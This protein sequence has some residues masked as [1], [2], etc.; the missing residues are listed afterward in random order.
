MSCRLH[1]DL[2]SWIKLGSLP[3]LEK[4]SFDWLVKSKLLTLNIY[5]FTPYYFPWI[6]VILR[7]FLSFLNSWNNKLLC[8]LECKRSNNIK[9]NTQIQFSMHSYYHI[10]CLYNSNFIGPK[11]FT[12]SWLCKRSNWK[13]NVCYKMTLWILVSFVVN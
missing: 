3:D 7:Y 4:I 12:S 1:K 5:W 6:S 8:L 10:I 13:K 9:V 11:T 2:R